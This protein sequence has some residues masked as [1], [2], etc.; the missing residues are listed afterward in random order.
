MNV[1]PDSARLGFEFH[2]SHLLCDLGPQFPRT[3]NG[4]CSGTLPPGVPVKMIRDPTVRR[5]ALAWP[6][7]SVPQRDAMLCTFRREG[8]VWGESLSHTDPP[9]ESIFELWTRAT[10]GTLIRP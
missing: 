5:L 4:G 8:P 6:G 1:A 2:L 9:G 10:N 3:W 7:R